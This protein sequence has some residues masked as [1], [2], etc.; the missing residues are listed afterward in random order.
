MNLFRRGRFVAKL[1]DDPATPSNC[2]HAK[3]SSH[4]GNEFS[5]GSIWECRCGQRW[6]FTGWGSVHMGHAYTEPFDKWE[7]V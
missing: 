2:K 4:R 3:P 1:F 6:R 7:K 5:A